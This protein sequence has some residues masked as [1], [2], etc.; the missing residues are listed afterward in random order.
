MY[1]CGKAK[2]CATCLH[3]TRIGARIPSA[4]AGCIQAGACTKW[5]AL[6]LEEKQEDI[7]KSTI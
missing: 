2:S 1:D 5:E 7:H 4:C 6:R 3:Q